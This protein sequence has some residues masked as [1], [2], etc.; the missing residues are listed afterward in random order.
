MKLP[1]SLKC[2]KHV[3]IYCFIESK[4]KH[5]G[6]CVVVHVHIMGRYLYGPFLQRY[7]DRDLDLIYWSTCKLMVTLWTVEY[8]VSCCSNAGSI[9]D[10]LY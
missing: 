1:L 2:A 7:I 4:S 8:S 5:I 9:I 10:K 3:A 6:F